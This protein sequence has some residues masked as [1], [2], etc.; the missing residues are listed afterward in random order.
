MKQIRN[1]AIGEKINFDAEKNQ[2]TD[3]FIFKLGQG[4]HIEQD[5]HKLVS[6]ADRVGLPWGYTWQQDARF[7][8]ESH[9]AS[10]KLA[11]PDGNT[12]K[13]KL[14]LAVELPFYPCPNWMYMAFPYAWYKPMESV[15]RGISEYLGYDLGIYTSASK[16]SFICG[17]MPLVL[18]QEFANKALLWEAQYKVAVPDK[19]GAWS[20]YTMWQYQE[21]P[22]Y[23]I[24]S[25]EDF[26]QLIGDSVPVTPPVPVPPT[27]HLLELHHKDTDLTE[28]V[29]FDGEF[30]LDNVDYVAVD[31]VHFVTPGPVLPIP[32]PEPTPVPEP[33]D[34]EL[35]LYRI[36]HDFELPVNDWGGKFMSRT[37][38]PKW[39]GRPMTPETCRIQSNKST[40]HLTP[41][42]QSMV[43]KLNP[44]KVFK[45]VTGHAMGWVNNAQWPHVE[46]LTFRGNKVDVI[47]IDHQKKRAYIRTWNGESDDPAVIH[48]WSNIDAR[49]NLY[50]TGR[51]TGYIVLAY[52]GDAWI[53][54]D[55]LV[56][57]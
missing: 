38:S 19:C 39:T 45:Y 44:F 25:D 48:T 36:L 16:W 34:P 37:G 9:K 31:S 42:A 4:Q 33:T 55:Q 7:S 5:V 14:W 41:E 29:S 12:G 22:D 52:P 56:K 2:G 49:N 32:T 24:I 21:N 8:P 46:S 23:S 57:V 1:L 50:D 20:R 10:I 54:L 30:E 18:Q 11:L 35:G 43:E 26:A 27:S 17:K 28:S 13:L 6:E 3:G 47:R 15:W 40:V 53:D 51:G